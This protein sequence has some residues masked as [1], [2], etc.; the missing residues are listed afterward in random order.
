ML[1]PLRNIR[2]RLQF[3]VLRRRS[4]CPTVPF[5]LGPSRCFSETII[6]NGEA[7]RHRRFSSLSASV[8]MRMLSSTSSIDSSSISAANTSSLEDRMKWRPIELCG[9]RLELRDRPGELIKALQVVANHNMNLTRVE[10]RPQ[11]LSVTRQ[12]FTLY[13]E[14]NSGGEEV[15]QVMEEIASACDTKVHR[16]LTPEVPWFP[17]TLSDID[18][19][20][21]STLDAGAELTSDHPGFND[22][23]YRSRRQEIVSLASEYKAGDTI[24]PVQYT[25]DEVACWEC[26]YDKLRMLC[27]KHGCAEYNQELVG[28]EKAGI[29]SP[30]RIPQLQEV[31][32]Y[33][34]QKTGC[35][36][37][38][39]A[40]SEKHLLLLFVALMQVFA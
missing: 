32:E 6:S 40:E 20:S 26:V 15:L 24:P 2:S 27:L 34:Q 10:H 8:Q 5:F 35:S 31:S 18:Q 28:L 16:V 37:R 33:L 17:S 39:V 11:P 7:W 19:F 23:T 38:D 13:F 36:R 22:Q 12:T 30:K 25:D 21:Q 29:Y 14:G 3:G 9:I 4:P 1:F